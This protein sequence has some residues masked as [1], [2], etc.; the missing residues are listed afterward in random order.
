MTQAL[1]DPPAI[2]KRLQLVYN[3]STPGATARSPG[4]L[5]CWPPPKQPGQRGGSG[6]LLALLLSRSILIWTVMFGTVS[7]SVARGLAG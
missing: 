4:S 1:V 6:R 3:W 5:R 7:G 2:N